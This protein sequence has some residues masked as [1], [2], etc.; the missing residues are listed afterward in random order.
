MAKDELANLYKKEI[1]NPFEDKNDKKQKVS[2]E[3]FMNNLQ[4]QLKNIKVRH[5][6]IE[7]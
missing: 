2:Y 4:E 5:Q 7:F 1:E 3:Q 6:D